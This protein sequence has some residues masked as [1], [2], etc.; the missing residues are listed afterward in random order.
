[1]PTVSKTI[2]RIL[3]ATDFAENAE[4]VLDQAVVMA[5]AF[6]AT[7]DIV[8]VRE[9]FAYAL[10]GGFVPSPQQ[11]EVLIDWIDEALVRLRDRAVRA[12]VPCVTCSLDGSPASAIVQ[13]AVKT[14]AQLV[15]MGTHGRTGIA[16]AVL[17]SVAERVV[18]K[19]RCPVM[20][21]PTHAAA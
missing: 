10:T 13:H 12:G 21:I 5:R 20:V 14:G 19:A 11:H 16:H 4:L 17:G 6:D 7:L 18:H 3:V 15:V 1:M 8:H 9:V 2:N